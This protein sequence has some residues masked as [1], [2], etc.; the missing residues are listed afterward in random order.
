GRLEVVRPVEVGRRDL[1][2]IDERQDVDALGTLGT[3]LLEI[4]VA[5]DDVPAVLVFESPYDAVV[6]DGL[7]G[8]LADLLIPDRR[9]VALVEQREV[10][11][12]SRFRR[13]Q[14]DRDVDEAERDAPVPE[15]RC[16]EIR[17]LS[18]GERDAIDPY[19]TPPSAFPR[20]ARHHSASAW[21]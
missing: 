19:P 21:S 17:Y 9:V 2:R 14:R 18:G 1:V 11:L 13:H 4:R 5:H 8:A 20:P 6:R 12:V 7:A 15:S 10:Q 3:R 16:H